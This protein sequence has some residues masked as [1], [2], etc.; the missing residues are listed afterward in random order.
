MAYPPPDQPGLS[1]LTSIVNAFL[2]H[3]SGS[4]SD[5]GK[6]TWEDHFKLKYVCVVYRAWELA[7][8]FGK[9]EKGIPK[10]EML[11]SDGDG[12]G[13]EGREVMYK[14][15]SIKFSPSLYNWQDYG[16]EWVERVEKDIA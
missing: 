1:V 15:A 12:G 4:T 6:F 5:S 14:A 13:E 9:P 7:S 16:F 11:M 8:E 2:S 10:A 3:A